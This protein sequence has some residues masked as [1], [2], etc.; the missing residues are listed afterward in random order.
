VTLQSTFAA[1]FAGIGFVLF[2]AAVWNERRMQHHRQPGV[3]YRDV[4][5][6][7]DGGWRRP[8]LFTPIGLSYQRRAS[9]FGVAGTVCLL[10]A[11]LAWTFLRGR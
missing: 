10:L 4:T 6:R 2:A 1:S 3:A 8:D 5:L 11:L 9:A 7:R